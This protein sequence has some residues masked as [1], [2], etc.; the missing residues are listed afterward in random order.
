MKKEI[1]KKHFL[2]KPEYAGGSKAIAEFIAHNLKYPESAVP[3]KIEGTVVLKGEINHKGEVIHTR[4]ISPLDP[5]CDQEAQ[6]VVSLLKFK[7]DKVRN[8]K[9]SFFKTFQI[10]F[11]IPKQTALQIQYVL[12]PQSETS[13]QTT[14]PTSFVYQIVL[15]E[16]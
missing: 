7:V 3:R 2:P 5:D 14:V 11:K 9:V 6:R 10:H 8:I 4:I 12:K 16:K 15:P 13:K 1:K